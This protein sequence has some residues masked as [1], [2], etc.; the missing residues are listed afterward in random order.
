VLVD[1]SPPLSRVA[2]HREGR[3]SVEQRELLCQFLVG[4]AAASR[5]IEV[6]EVAALRSAYRAL[7]VP[8]ERLDALLADAAAVGDQPVE[9]Q[10]GRTSARQGEAI[11]PRDARVGQSAVILDPG[12]LRQIFLDTQ[13]VQSV[14][15]SVMASAEELTEVQ[16]TPTALTAAAAAPA[17]PTGTGGMPAALA[18]LD[19]RYQ[20]VLAEVLARDEWSEQDFGELVRR[21]RLMPESTLE[22]INTWAQEHLGDFLIEAGETLRVRKDLVRQA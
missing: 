11:P 5:V 13:A 6:K 22:R 16:T 3:L 10:T 2:Q 8:P 20:L 18:D 19:P 1:R 12:K 4:I 15:A 9:V 7:G 14:L 17:S 21:H